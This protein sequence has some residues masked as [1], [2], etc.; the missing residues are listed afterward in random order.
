MDAAHG[1]ASLLKQT[2]V[3]TSRFMIIVSTKCLTI[4]S[5]SNL[6]NLLSIFHR[7]VYNVRA[8]V[9]VAI[10]YHSQYG[11]RSGSDSGGNCTP[12]TKGCAVRPHTCA[13]DHT[14]FW[15]KILSPQPCPC[16]QTVTLVTR[17]PNPP[18]VCDAIDIKFGNTSA[19]F[20]KKL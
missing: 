2:R 10:I 18:P 20:L 17:C 8:C 4:A 7:E 14:L 1:A 9:Q 19:L 16:K 3:P 6:L 5:H 15:V 11:I 13:L 12:L